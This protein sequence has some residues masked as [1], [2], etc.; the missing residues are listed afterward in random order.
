MKLDSVQTRERESLKDETQLVMEEARMVLPGIQ[1]LFG[2][3]LIAIFNARFERLPETAQH[4]HL[5]ALAF[6]ALAIALVMAP[7]AYHR[8]GERGWVS[9]RLV[10]LA[11]DFLGYGMA[12]LMFGLTLDVA[13]V[14][15]MILG[16]VAV[17]FAAGLA[18]LLVFASLWFLLPLRHRWRRRA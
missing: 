11:S 7:A 5:T 9:R 3:Q 2:F 8:L 16:N 14:I 13:L 6:V 17:S 10:D 18:A 15:Y 12:A 4:V 1:S